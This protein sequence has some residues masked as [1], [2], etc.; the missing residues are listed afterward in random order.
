MKIKM[1][2]TA[3][4][5]SLSITVAA[6][7]VTTAEAYEVA[8][9]DVRL[10]NNEVGTI[11]FKR[12]PDC[13]FETRRVNRGT[14]YEFNGQSMSLEKFKRSLGTVDRSKNIPV[15]VLHHLESNQ[16]TK[17]WVLVP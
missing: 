5:L 8:L 3:L 11:G 6:Q 15:Q 14:V 2:V 12:C 1:I 4:L 16:V 10:P 17:V 9:S 13:D 7:F